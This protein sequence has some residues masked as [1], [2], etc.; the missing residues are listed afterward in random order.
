MSEQLSER[1][2]R[3]A[4]MREYQQ[5]PHA[6]AYRRARHFMKRY[7]ITVEEYETRVAD[8]RGLC[9]ACGRVPQGERHHAELHVDHDHETGQVRGLLCSPCN[10][11]LGLLS[12]DPNRM[13]GLI[14][15][16]EG[17]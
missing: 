6:K 13:R 15:Y 10:M 16:I 4:Y 17:E 2:K 12:D 8:Q 1:E 5:R 11:A 3:N 14:R 9:A 7:G